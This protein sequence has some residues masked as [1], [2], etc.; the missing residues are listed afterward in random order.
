MFE[1]IP[2]CPYSCSVKKVVPV[3]HE[4]LGCFDNDAN[5]AFSSFLEL[6]GGAA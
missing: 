1:E 6:Y 3:G 4:L 5:T 2:V